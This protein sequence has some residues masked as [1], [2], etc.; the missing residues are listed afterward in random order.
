VKANFRVVLFLA[1]L[2]L[3][4]AGNLWAQPAYESKFE[5]EEPDPS[6]RRWSVSG[7]IIYHTFWKQGLLNNGEAYGRPGLGVSDLAGF[8]GEIEFDYHIRPFLVVTGTV[9]GYQGKTDLYKIEI[10]TGYALATAKLQKVTRLA[11]YYIGAGV[12][13]YFSR[14]DADDTSNAL[15][16]GIHGL[17]GIRIHVTPK[18]SI[19]LEDRLAF[20]LRA[21]EGFGDLDLGGNFLMLGGTRHF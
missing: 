6:P 9:G 3:A 21:E 16:P 12:G 2:L 1:A 8:G 10:I 5:P 13:G 4:A 15:K 11:D 19:S 18:W 14:M 7:K 20:T 17:L